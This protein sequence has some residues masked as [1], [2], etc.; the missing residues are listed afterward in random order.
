[1]RKRMLNGRGMHAWNYRRS[2][3]IAKESMEDAQHPSLTRREISESS[4]RRATLSSAGL[5]C[6][7][8]SLL[9]DP[10]MRNARVRVRLRCG[11]I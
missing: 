9:N 10:S 1:M 7:C 5:P 2:T 11:R 3:E 8:I 6:I 4:T